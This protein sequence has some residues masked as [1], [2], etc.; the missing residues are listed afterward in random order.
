M[1]FPPCLLYVNPFV[2][3]TYALCFCSTSKWAVGHGLTPHEPKDEPQ[4]R[5]SQPGS[6]SS[7]ENIFSLF[8][9]DSEYDLR[10]ENVTNQ[11][12]VGPKTTDSYRCK[13]NSS[14]KPRAYWWVSKSLICREKQKRLKKQNEGPY[15]GRERK[16]GSQKTQAQPYL[17]Q[18]ES[19]KFCLI[20]T[21]WLEENQNTH[22]YT[23]MYTYMYI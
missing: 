11:R 6:H 1:L 2:C 22:K 15:K 4:L 23:N 5:S 17:L 12:M 8:L 21:L 19:V 10:P 9:Q 18:L 16:S 20:K 13:V 7:T 14:F 3:L